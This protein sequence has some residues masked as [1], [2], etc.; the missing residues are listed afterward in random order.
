MG[1]AALIIHAGGVRGG[2]LAGVVVIIHAGGMR[3]VAGG[4]YRR[5]RACRAR[6]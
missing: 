3:G 5:R 1:E 4:D 6:R 2:G